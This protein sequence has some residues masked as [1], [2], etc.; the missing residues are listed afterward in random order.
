MYVDLVLGLVE[1]DHLE[2]VVLAVRGPADVEDGAV[3]AAA[4]GPHHRELADA[5]VAHGLPRG[6]RVQGKNRSKLDTTGSF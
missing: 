1:F 5:K 4:Q 6:A 3:G 2:R